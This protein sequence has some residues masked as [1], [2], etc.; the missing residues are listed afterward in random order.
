MWMSVQDDV[1]MLLLGWW[2]QFYN[3]VCGS[4]GDILTICMSSFSC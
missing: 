4:G 3:I 2:K 1:L